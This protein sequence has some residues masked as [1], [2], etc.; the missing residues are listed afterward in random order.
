[1]ILPLIHIGDLWLMFSSL[2]WLILDQ[3]RQNKYQTI[4]LSVYIHNLMFFSIWVK[5]SEKSLGMV[6]ILTW[7]RYKHVW[8]KTEGINPNY[9]S[10]NFFYFY[11]VIPCQI[12]TKKSLSPPIWTKIG[13]YT[14]SVKTLIHSEFQRSSLYGLRVR[15][16]QK[17]DFLG[18]F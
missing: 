13:S 4:P 12:N 16:R 9:T 5:C 18:K 7:T 10:I 8:A 14:V 3:S 2:K 17:I 6:V 1:M 15:A 11:R